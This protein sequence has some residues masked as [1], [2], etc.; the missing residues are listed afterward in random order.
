MPMTKR[1]PGVA[2]VG[3]HLRLIIGGAEPHPPTPNPEPRFPLPGP[4]PPP[5]PKR[6]TP[7]PSVVAD[8]AAPA[9]PEEGLPMGVSALPAAAWRGIVKD[10]AQAKAARELEHLRER[11]TELEHENRRLAAAV[12][13][14]RA[15]GERA[16]RERTVRTMGNR[17]PSILTIGA[18]R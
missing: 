14:A 4:W 7:P 17:L 18:R 12:D 16:E 1:N 8:P 13:A 5:E 3:E 2:A 15:E 10:L 6:P 9:P 11:V